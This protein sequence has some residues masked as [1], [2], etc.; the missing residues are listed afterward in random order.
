MDANGKKNSWECVVQIPFINEQ[1][2]GLACLEVLSVDIQ[3][4]QPLP[5]GRSLPH[6]PLP[7]GRSLPAGQLLVDTV[8]TINHQQVRN[9]TGRPQDMRVCGSVGLWVSGSVCDSV[10]VSL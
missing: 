3:A 10:S 9:Q 8:S 2:R 1:V 7:L 4:R 5:S 6:L